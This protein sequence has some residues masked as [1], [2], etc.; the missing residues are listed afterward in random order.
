MTGQ[1]DRAVLAVLAVSFRELLSAGNRRCPGRWRSAVSSKNSGGRALSLGEKSSAVQ[2]AA[3][4][5]LEDLGGPRTGLGQVPGGQEAA[6]PPRCPCA[7]E[8]P[9]LLSLPLRTFIPVSQQPPG[10]RSRGAQAEP[11]PQAWAQTPPSPRWPLQG[12]GSQGQGRRGHS[13]APPAAPQL[14]RALDA[15][16]A[17][18]PQAHFTTALIQRGVSTLQKIGCRLP[19]ESV[20]LA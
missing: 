11:L 3:P 5:L 20:R 17:L 15:Q 19:I 12:P 16:E 8:S 10:G 6:F 2:L 9:R 18:E 7:C 14:G 13:S 1:G 4:R